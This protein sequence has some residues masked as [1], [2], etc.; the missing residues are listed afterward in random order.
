MKKTVLL[1]PAGSLTACKAAVSNYCVENGI[2]LSTVTHIDTDKP[3][4]A[5]SN[6]LID[7]QPKSVVGYN[8]PIGMFSK[9][10]REHHRRANKPFFVYFL[11]G[12]HSTASMKEVCSSI[13][14]HDLTKKQEEKAVA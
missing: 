11:T 2:D 1:C 10:H 14:V 4:E 3:M 6:A 13:L 7:E 8:I 12:K 9:F 5:I